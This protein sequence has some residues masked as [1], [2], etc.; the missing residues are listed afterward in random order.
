MPDGGA[1][2]DLIV[3]QGGRHALDIL[4]T[5]GVGRVA[6]LF[7][8]S[9]YIAFDQGWVCL[10]ADSLPMGPMN[11][12]SS[13]PHGMIWESR[14][15]QIDDR[16]VSSASRLRVGQALEF[17][18][19]DVGTW[20]PPAPPPWTALTAKGGL[21]DLDRRQAGPGTDAGLAGFVLADRTAGPRN[22]VVEAAWE[23]IEILS[24]TAERA[25]GGETLKSAELDD[26]VVALLGLGPGLTPSGDDFL[27]GMLIALEVLPVSALR[28]HLIASIECHAQRRT[29][30]I[31]LAHLRAAGLGA[32]HEALHEFFNSLLAGDTAT[33]PAQLTAI[34]KIGHSS[35]WDALAGICVTLRAYLAAQK[36]G[37]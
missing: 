12:R 4:K 1:C 32:G 15:L 37:V 14:F 6:A 29:N 31:S 13:A 19:G 11:V 18:T 34:D 26:A 5:G 16:V 25:I 24:R 10:G 28:A 33:L 21:D 20:D 36:M 22:E 9:F 27:C 2:T 3:T 23:P 7:E 30:A 8:R 17:G 35:G